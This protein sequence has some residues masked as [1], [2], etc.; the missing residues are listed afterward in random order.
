[1]RSSPELNY[2]KS[3]D[4]TCYHKIWKHSM[5]QYVRFLSG[6]S[7]FSIDRCLHFFAC[8]VKEMLF[9]LFK[10]INSNNFSRKNKKAFCSTCRWWC[11]IWLFKLFSKDPCI[12]APCLSTPIGTA[13]LARENAKFSKIFRGETYD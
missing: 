12:C 9:L 13:R 11:Y 8:E 10:K 7:W 6:T 1:M 2:F 3:V 5:M 4:E